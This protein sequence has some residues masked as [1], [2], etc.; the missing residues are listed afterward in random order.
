M[1]FVIGFLIFL[2]FVCFVVVEKSEQSIC[3][4]KE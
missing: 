4:F 2:M 1:V 3:V